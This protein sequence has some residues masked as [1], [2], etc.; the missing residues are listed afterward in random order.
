MKNP[1]S[2]VVQLVPPKPNPFQTQIE[3]H[4]ANARSFHH[5]FLNVELRSSGSIGDTSI[6]QQGQAGHLIFEEDVFLKQLCKFTE[7]LS[8][9][10]PRPEW[11]KLCA[12]AG[13]I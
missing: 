7:A 6:N 1:A 10:L 8:L 4:E 5:A 11:S 3:Q 9:W 2:T 13:A 12:S